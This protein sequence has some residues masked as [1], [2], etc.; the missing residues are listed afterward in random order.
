MRRITII[1][2]IF[3]FTG[4]SL[5]AQVEYVDEKPFQPVSPV[6]MAQGGSFLAVPDGYNSLFYNPAGFKMTDGLGKLTLLSTTLWTYL[7]PAIAQSVLTAVTSGPENF[8]LEQ[9]KPVQLINDTI[10]GGGLGM[11]ISLGAGWVGNGLGLG[12]AL[13]IDSMFFGQRN[14]LDL[15]A[16]LNVTMGFV[17]GYALELELLGINF[18]IGADLR[19]MYRIR[20][21]LENNDA[22]RMVFALPDGDLDTVFSVMNSAQGLTGFGV[23]VDL[24]V[25]AEL[26]IFQAALSVRDL[27]GTEFFYTYNGFDVI[28]EDI[29]A[30]NT[31][32][33]GTPVDPN[34][35]YVIPMD[36]SAG[37]AMQLDILEPL[38][39]LKVHA[40]LQDVIGV[41]KYQRSP[42]TL[43]HVGAEATILKILKARIGFNQGYFTMG[44]GAQV[45]FAD[46]NVALFTRELGRYIGDQP[47]SGI[48]LEVA[49]RL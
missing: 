37:A 48:T 6:V 45:L 20:A 24:G 39:G 47:N 43:L 46:I 13:V 11:G 40:D 41:I 14:M 1:T 23:G 28:F 21:H 31:P 19:P 44:A 29:A 16:D 32:R 17:I 49:L 10:S 33:E 5:F 2:A 7:N 18:N 3:I 15:T 35:K 9:T 26:G 4:L 42:W 30:G 27:F 22:I 34:M 12:S 25:V 8:D 36:I 38:L